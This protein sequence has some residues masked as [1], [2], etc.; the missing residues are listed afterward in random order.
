MLEGK[1]HVEYTD[2]PLKMKNQSMA[3]ASQA[4]DLY[5]VLD[6]KS[7]AA[8]IKKVFYH[9]SVALVFF[10]ESLCLTFIF[11]C[12]WIKRFLYGPFVELCEFIF[13]NYSSAY[14]YNL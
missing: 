5:D 3:A 11:L 7:I 8:H 2:M 6:C 9:L 4:L 12:I 13:Q 14:H 10:P 1:G